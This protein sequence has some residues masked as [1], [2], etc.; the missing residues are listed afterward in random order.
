ME[1]IYFGNIK[2]WGYGAGNGPWIMADLENG[3]FSGVN[4]HY[5]ANDPTVNYRYL[6]AIGQGRP[7]PVGD[8]GRQRAVR[9]PVHVLQWTAAQRLRLQPDAQ[10]GRDH[11]RHRR[12][13]QQGFRRH[14]LRGRHDLRLPLGRHRELGA[15]QHHGG[16]IRRRWRRRGPA[17]GRC[18]RSARASAWTCR[19]STTTLG[20]QLQIYDCN[21]PAEPG[22]DAYLLQ[23]ADGLRSAARTLCL[24]AYGQG[25]SAGTK[26]VTWSCNGQANQQ[27]TFN[28]NGTITGV[29]SGLCLDV[30][31]RVHRQ[32]RAGRTVDLQRRQQPAVDSRL[33][34]T[35]R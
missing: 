34:R 7:E 33:T 29:Q 26:V 4:Q 11:P 19:T 17:P 6:T 20:T 10:G 1:A 8:P 9:R 25:T 21:G 23:P 28:S 13:Q 30:T 32:R 14:L 35:D 15:G 22:L 2:V 31:E 27:W 24:D 18:T 16:R 12:R 3:L 5:N